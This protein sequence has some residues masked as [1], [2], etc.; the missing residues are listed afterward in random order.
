MT[1]TIVFIT[2]P[3]YDDDR[4]VHV[5]RAVCVAVHGAAVQLRD[6]L[7]DDETLLPLA[8]RLRE[9]TRENGGI[10]LINRR[11]ALATACEADGVHVSANDV[12]RARRFFG[13][14]AIIS[15][16]AHSVDQ[17]L[18]ARTGGADF[19][20]V[21]PVFQSP[22]KGAGRGV[23]ALTAAVARAGPHLGVVALGGVDAT[24]AA[25]CFAAGARGVAA[26]RALLGE[27]DAG[28]VAARMVSGCDVCYD[29]L[30]R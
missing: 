14:H 25:C 1:P 9:V 7:R 4:L 2:D 6:R 15:A 21:S 24:N 18:E 23:V 8:T 16:P 3:A 26:I 17:V 20:L 28:A 11:P 12:A 10:L 29:S 27:P 13:A 22:G 5:A 19:A 30:I